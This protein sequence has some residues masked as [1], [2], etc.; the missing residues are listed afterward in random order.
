MLSRRTFFY[1][2]MQMEWSK[3]HQLASLKDGADRW[4]PPYPLPLC[5]QIRSPHIHLSPFLKPYLSRHDMMEATREAPRPW[6]WHWAPTRTWVA[7]HSCGIERPL[8]TSSTEGM[9]VV[10]AEEVA[11]HPYHREAPRYELDQ[12]WRLWQL[13]T[14]LPAPPGHYGQIFRRRR[15]T[16]TGATLE[17]GTLV[18]SSPISSQ[19]YS[20]YDS[21]CFVCIWLCTCS[22]CAGPC[23]LFSTSSRHLASLRLSSATTLFRCK[24][25]PSNEIVYHLLFIFVLSIIYNENSVLFPCCLSLYLTWGTY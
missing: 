11:T 19:N 18:L 22:V 13:K 20:H 10:T 17:S 6:L 16:M 12:A 3:L 1:R 4:S 9:V 7:H 5:S 15:G 14:N 23:R 25:A 21:I 2:W 24:T 8:A